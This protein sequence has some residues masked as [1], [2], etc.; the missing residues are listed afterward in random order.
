MT[1][2]SAGLIQWSPTVPQ[3]G[4]HTIAVRFHSPTGSSEDHNFTISVRPVVANT[5][6]KII[7][8]PISLATTGRLYR[9]DLVAQD[10]DHDALA[11]ELLSAPAGMS[12]QPSTGSIRWQP[13]QDQLG[14]STVTIQVSDPQG[15][16]TT[17]IFSLT[18]FVVF[19]S[20]VD[21]VGISQL[22]LKVNDRVVAL[23][24]NHVA[25]LYADDWGFG[26]LNMV[27][28]ARDAAGN[29]GWGSGVSFYRN[30]DVDYEAN[31]AVPTA[32]VTS[33]A[34]DESVVGMV[35][36]EGTAAG[37][38]FKEYRLLYARADNLD[39]IEFAHAT[40]QV[41]AGLLGTWDTTL[42]E[43]DAY[44]VRLEV[45]DL[46]GSTSVVDVPVGLSGALKLGN[47][48]LSF[49]DMT[50]PVAGIPITIVRTYDTLRADRQGDFG[51]GWRLEYRDTDL[52][53]SLPKSGLEDMGIYTPFKQGTK[54]YLTLP[55]GERQGFTFT[56]EY[57]VL[58]GFG[59]GN[60][61]VIAFPRFTPDRGVSS[62]LNAG[63]GSLLVNEFGEMYTAGGIPWNPASPDLS[64]YTLTTPDGIRYQIDG[65]TG[66]MNSVTDRNANSIQFSAAGISSSTGVAI[67][68][69][70][71]LKGRIQ[72]ITDPSGSNMSY[73]YSTGGDLLAVTDRNG[74]T[75]TFEYKVDSVHYLDRIIDPLGRTGIRT[76]YDSD[77]RLIGTLALDGNPTSLAYSPENQLVTSVNAAGQQTTYVY[78]MQGNV[79]SETD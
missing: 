68:I 19:V 71:D 39:F 50:I 57:R 49:E 2:D 21:N 66:L 40:T 42:L 33:P 56:P 29:V 34:I 18:T 14:S 7:S 54:V 67:S 60:D 72:A 47:F 44:I 4:L 51:Y 23:D 75:T 22:E 37:P 30:P 11:Y 36:I 15:G 6:P 64:G 31:P 61:L 41:Q 62:T 77:G 69:E 59:Q 73:K 48:R 28:T 27:A 70:R 35:R 52:R 26:T 38:D 25:R 76:Q 43:N 58:P 45:T 5:S 9:Y 1:L 20:A 55:G 78:D 63:S 13:A 10:P 46:I 24:A 17:Q 79:V 65:A 16:S 74:N 3:L 8:R 32:I 12:I 53:T